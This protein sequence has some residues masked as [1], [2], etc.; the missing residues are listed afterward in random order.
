MLAQNQSN[1]RRD[2]EHPGNDTPEAPPNPCEEAFFL[3][4]NLIV[5][6]SGKSLLYFLSF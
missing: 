6:I 5:P 4:G 2:F 1:Q 3:F